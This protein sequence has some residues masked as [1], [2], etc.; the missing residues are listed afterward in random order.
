MQA[1]VH[2]RL[3]ALVLCAMLTG[4]AAQAQAESRYFQASQRSF[5]EL[6]A[7]AAILSADMDAPWDKNACNYY[8]AT[9]MTYAVRCH[10]L[11]QLTD[12]A[13]HM[14]QPEDLALL[15]RKIGQ[16]LDYVTRYTGDDLKVLEDLASSSR[17][18]RIRELGLKLVNVLRV[19]ER[20]AQA[21]PRG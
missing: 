3:C 10:A 19:F 6:A 5:E 18:A 12:V 9:A 13:S 2:P 17:N 11:A 7:Q 21:V 16:T 14:R 1:H 15:R 4:L 8:A 20:N